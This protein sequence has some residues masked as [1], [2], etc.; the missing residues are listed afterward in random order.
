MNKKLLL[1]FIVSFSCAMQ[2]PQQKEQIFKVGPNTIKLIQGNLLDQGARNPKVKAAI[3]NA[4]NESLI[5]SAGVAAAIQ[6]AAGPEF[7]KYITTKIPV[8]RPSKIWGQVRVEV[9]NA[10][11]TPAFNLTKKGIKNIINAVGPDLRDP[12]Q[13]KNKEALL[14]AVYRNSLNVAR[15]YDI[16]RISFPAISSGIFGYQAQ[17]SAPVAIDKVIKF[18][19]VN[20]PSKILPQSYEVR[21]MSSRAR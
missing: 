18:L 11:V 20:K 4:A 17:D 16:N 13:A 15:S 14:R 10:Y 7:E 1:L 5:G 3:V 8:L 12:E 19:T 21:F 2:A 9:G 6:N